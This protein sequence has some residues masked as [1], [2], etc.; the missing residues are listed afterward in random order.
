MLSRTF[1]KEQ[2]Q[3]H[4]LKHKQ[5]PPQI[6][7][8]IMKHDQLKPVHC[9]VKHEEI[10]YNQKNDCNLLLDDYGEDQF[11]IR[12][13]NKGEDIHRKTLDLFSF[14]SI[15]QFESKDLQKMKQNH[16]YNN[17]LSLS[18]LIFLVMKM[19]LIIHKI[20]K[21]KTQLH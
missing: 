8:S 10:T 1:N 5:L 12:I 7:F 21:I 19:K 17:Q 14:Q 3:I 11:S 6:N 4:Q 2:L 20:Q 16:F 15:V 9:L 18:T 13:N